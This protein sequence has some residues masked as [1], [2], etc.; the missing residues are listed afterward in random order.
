MSKGFTGPKVRE[1][2]NRLGVASDER[3]F[4]KLRQQLIHELRQR[5][6][7]GKIVLDEVDNFVEAEEMMN[8]PASPSKTREERQVEKA[9]MEEYATAESSIRHTIRLTMNK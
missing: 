1:F 5:G 6:Y 4:I 7:Q 8:V 9:I 3:N 2:L